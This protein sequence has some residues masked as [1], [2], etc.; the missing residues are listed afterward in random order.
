MVSQNAQ[1]LSH[2]QY[3]VQHIAQ[4]LGL[5]PATLRS[6]ERRYGIPQP[7]RSSNGYRVYTDADLRLLRRLKARLDA[8]VRIGL[9]VEEIRSLL[10]G[11]AG[12]TSPDQVAPDPHRLRAQLIEAIG[13]L[14]EGEADLAL[15]LALAH[16]PL[17]FVL[18]EILEPTLRWVGEAW[19]RGR[20]PVA[21]EHLA[22]A[23]V[24][25]R[26]IVQFSA[27]P[28]PW[29]G[30]LVLA[31]GAPADQH[32]LGLLC[33]SLALRE[34]GWDVRY[35]GS[36]L[37]FEEIEYAADTL[38]PGLVA[39]SA[40]LPLDLSAQEGLVTLARHL[41]QQGIGAVLGGQAFRSAGS[42]PGAT[43][44]HGPLH[45]LL[46]RVDAVLE[47]GLHARG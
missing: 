31:V 15:D 28:E 26:L 35:L 39:F 46:N 45:E 33:L 20:L 38:S 4:L 16:H 9:A 7:A 2:R 34:R 14:D 42:I 29:R 8:G 3:S 19:A 13:R 40:T 37:P 36:G 23:V 22:S 41:S 27:S 21:A 25:R 11:D 17:E 12:G 47:G 10:P 30:E 6:W 1:S 43:I 44:L 5:Q 32:S 18:S 24:T